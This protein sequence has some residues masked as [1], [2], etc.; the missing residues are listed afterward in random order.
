M[1]LS[2][3]IQQNHDAIIAEW[4][5]FARTVPVAIQMDRVALRD[6]IVALLDFIVADLDTNQNEKEQSEKSKGLRDI[7]GN[8][9]DSPGE[10]HAEQR[11][12]GGFDTVEMLSEF[13][14]LRASVVKLWEAET[15]KA[16]KDFKDL[17]RFNESIDQ[18]MTESLIRYTEKI[19]EARTLFLGTL[20]HDLRN[21]LNAVLMSAQLLP[22]LGEFN[23]KQIQL[24][25]QIETSTLR[26]SQ[27][28]STLIDEVRIR[29]GQG[30]PISAAPMN[31][32]NTMRDAV[33]EVKATHPLRE[34][35][36]HTEGNLQGVWDKERLSQVLS[37]LIGNAIQHGAPN[38][39]IHLTAKESLSGVVIAVQNKGASIPPSLLPRIFDPLTRGKTQNSAQPETYSMGLGLFITK[40]IVEGHGG[41]IHVLSNATE[42]T[43]F[44]AELPRIAKFVESQI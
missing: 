39:D 38:E 7:A 40:G 31:L 6:H 3:F 42:G 32:E 17:I 16:E 26:V 8:E 1:G 21:P 43:V 44:S 14:A 10:S 34:I 25:S 30:L 23:T 35:I 22:R 9:K 28:V 37:N 2:I 11:F 29:L 24:V 4:E 15:H 20:M 41:K 13:R 27:L 19:D 33:A 12:L 5:K 36:V 18:M